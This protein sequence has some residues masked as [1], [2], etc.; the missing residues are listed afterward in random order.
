[1]ERLNILITADPLIPVPPVYYG[2]I[3]RII[4][5]LICGLHKYGHKVHLFA[6]PDSSAPAEIVPLNRKGNS[7]K[8]AIVYA[9]QIYKYVKKN[10]IDII[11]SFGRLAYLF[12]LM[13]K[14]TPKI[15]S[16]QR[17]ICARSIWLGNLLGRESI[18]FTACSYS[19]MRNVAHLGR[20]EV[21]P[22]GVPLENFQ[23]NHQVSED[24]PLVFLSR[25]E[26]IKGAH[27][28]IE[29]AQR[30]RKN[31]ILA[32]S[33]S[34]TGE[35]YTYFIK[36]ILPYCDGKN[37]RYI[38][39]VDDLKKNELLGMASALLFPVEW[40]EPF[41][42]VMVEALACGTPV[43]AF[44]RGAVPEVI[45]DGINGFLCE[46]KEGMVKAVS[47]IREIDRAKC[48]QIVEKKFSNEVIVKRYLNLYYRL[49]NKKLKT[50][51]S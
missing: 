30:T 19:C 15:Q 33:Y 47:R 40:E 43:I 31:L 51:V 11:H 4:Y 49:L 14:K 18:T 36:E 10:N 39:P 7:L 46:S 24:A 50:D 8:D 20:W 1:M 23:F 29:I 48:R 42:I 6:H 26:P 2:G 27:I 9:L 13:H 17:P 32:G 34:K 28:A 3:E 44:K 21:I 22:N 12:F 41:G 16:Y 25:L 38:G 45:E 37:I 5:M 35:N